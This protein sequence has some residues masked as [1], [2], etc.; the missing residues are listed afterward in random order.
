MKTHLI[1][2]RGR[3]EIATKQFSWG[4]FM[5]EYQG[6]LIENTDAKKQEDHSTGCY[7]DI[8]AGE[9]LLYDYGSHSKASM[10]AYP[11][12]KH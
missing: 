2:G 6:D 7:I 1:D 5:V 4:D 8:A 3:G 9:E 11:W 10:K 12:L